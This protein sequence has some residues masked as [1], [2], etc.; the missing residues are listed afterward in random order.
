MTQQHLSQRRRHWKALRR[1]T[2]WLLLVWFLVS[3]AVSFFARDLS[4]SF[5]GWPF[6]FWMG[7]QG[8]PLIYGLITAFYAWYVHRLD[9]RYGAVDESGEGRDE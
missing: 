7:A 4:F 5:F 6:S 8:A 9:V 3:F 2:V 1:V